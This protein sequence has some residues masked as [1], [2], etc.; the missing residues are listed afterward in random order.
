MTKKVWG[1]KP[2]WTRRTRGNQYRSGAV[3]LRAVAEI[4]EVSEEAVAEAV[5]T[6]A[7]RLF[8]DRVP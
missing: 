2:Q 3:S 6:N 4:K 5:R 1:K 7:R 8:G